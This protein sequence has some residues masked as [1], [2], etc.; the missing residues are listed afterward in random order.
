MPDQVPLSV[1]RWRSLA[2]NWCATYTNLTPDEILA[3]VWNES[4][5]NPLAENPND[6]SWGLMQ[7]TRP[8]AKF[9]GG[10]ADEDT[11]WQTDANKNMKCGAG[12][13]SD[14]KKKYEQKFP[15]SDAQHGWVVAY[16]E[17]EG[18]LRKRVPDPNYESGFVN[19]LAALTASHA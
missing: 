16:N 7:V 17:G 5:G 19:H 4:W 9:Y 1:E 2:E 13:L 11:S 8:I 12:F 15:L 18:N 14:L 6:P 3:I 10:F